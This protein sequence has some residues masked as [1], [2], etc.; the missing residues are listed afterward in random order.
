MGEVPPPVP[1]PTVPGLAWLEILHRP[2]PEAFASAYTQDAILEASVLRDP[3]R[4]AAAIRTVSDATRRLYQQIAFL[5]EVR[6]GNRTYLE[7][8]GRFKGRDVAGVTIL[9]H[10]ARGLIESVRLY[11]HPYD[12]GVTFSTALASRLAEAVSG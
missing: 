6:S 8:E 3:T 5:H 11:H 4:G 2:T 1:S 12:Q 10:D 7:W 9:V